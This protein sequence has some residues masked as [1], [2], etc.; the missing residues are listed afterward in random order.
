MRELQPCLMSHEG[1][2]CAYFAGGRMCVIYQIRS[3]S[4][5]GLPT[6]TLCNV[7][8]Q[9]DKSLGLMPVSDL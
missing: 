1:F 5:P 8:E 9:D 7:T 2:D 4:V 6:I 3:S